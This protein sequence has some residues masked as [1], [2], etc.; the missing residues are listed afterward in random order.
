MKATG[1]A[2]AVQLD[3]KGHVL[4]MLGR[5]QPVFLP[6][7]SLLFPGV[8]TLKDVGRWCVKLGGM[9]DTWCCC[10]QEQ[11]RRG[12]LEA[13]MPLPSIKGTRYLRYIQTVSEQNRVTTSEQFFCPPSPDAHL[14]V[15]ILLHKMCQMVFWLCTAQLTSTQLYPPPPSAKRVLSSMLPLGTVSWPSSSPDC[16]ECPFHG[17]PSMEKWW[18]SQP[19]PC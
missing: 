10:L 5:L 18:L 17:H 11:W 19:K 12:G 9:T 1:W 6:A 13:G 14:L 7:A 3:R 4:E 2:L 16:W 8:K 15:A